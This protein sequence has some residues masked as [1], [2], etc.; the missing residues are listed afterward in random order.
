MPDLS[1][2][3]LV[4]ALLGLATGILRDAARAKAED[5]T[6]EWS[7]W[8]GERYIQLGARLVLVVGLLA[9]EG[10]RIVE[11]L[12][13]TVDLPPEAAKLPAPFLVGVFGDRIVKTVIEKSE[14]VLQEVPGFRRLMSL[15]KKLT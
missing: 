5:S 14:T 10:S 4:F 11:T 15:G 7:A 2:T 1:V 8:L 3:T 6:F 13:A 9:P 12:L